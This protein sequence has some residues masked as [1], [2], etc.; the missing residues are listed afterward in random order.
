MEARQAKHV[1]FVATQ[2]KDLDGSCK[3]PVIELTLP[4]IELPSLAPVVPATAAAGVEL[5]IKEQLVSLATALWDNISNPFGVGPLQLDSEINERRRRERQSLKLWEFGLCLDMLGDC[6]DI[7]VQ[8]GE[9]D[10]LSTAKEVLCS[11]EGLLLRIV[12]LAFSYSPG[13]NAY[14]GSITGEVLTHSLA[15]RRGDP[16]VLLKVLQSPDLK[17]PGVMVQCLLSSG[18]L[19]SVLLE[20]VVGEL[21]CWESLPS[22][23]ELNVWRR[24]DRIFE[25]LVTRAA[26]MHESSGTQSLW[27]CSGEEHVMVMECFDVRPP[28]CSSCFASSAEAR[29]RGALEEHP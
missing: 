2:P 3:L 27:Q 7:Y 25:A 4:T 10:A 16:A 24:W 22:D 13:D 28:S 17:Q 15:M 5:E 11:A 1:Q 12:E 8:E 18:L 29:A 19:P 23:T 6:L 20:V 14:V 9:V 21:T 26:C